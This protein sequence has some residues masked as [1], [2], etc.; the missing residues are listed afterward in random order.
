MKLCE[1]YKCKRLALGMTQAELAEI[2]GVSTIT[3]SRFEKGEELSTRTFECIRRG[4]EDYI[5]SLEPNVYIET[6]LIEAALGLRYQRDD[7]KPYILS[8]MIIH[9]G[10]LNCNLLRM[11]K[12]EES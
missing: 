2:V 11:Q 9:A 5:R 3:L 10:K 8:H 4:V 6:R 1:S 12:E 7:E